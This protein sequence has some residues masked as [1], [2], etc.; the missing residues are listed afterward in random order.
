MPTTN[1]I[2]NSLAILIACLTPA[3]AG[4]LSISGPAKVTDDDTIIIDGIR[5]RVQGLVAEEVSMTNGPKA[6]VE[7]RNIVGDHIITCKLDGHRSYNRMVAICYLP[8]WHR[9]CP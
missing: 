7:M 2:T 9:H 4:P 3:V 8:G 5:I 6:T 1:T